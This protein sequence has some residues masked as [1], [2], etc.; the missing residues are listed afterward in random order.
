M[1]N[2]TTLFPLV[3]NQGEQMG[4]GLEA[5]RRTRCWLS[6][7]W[8]EN[9]AEDNEAKQGWKR[10]TGGLKWVDLE[11]NNIGKRTWEKCKKYWKGEWVHLTS[12][13][14]PSSPPFLH[15]FILWDC[16]KSGISPQATACI[17]TLSCRLSG[18][19]S[20][21]LILGFAPI[22]L[23]HTWIVILKSSD[24]PLNN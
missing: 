17:W 6:K 18:T 23:A 16:I 8:A 20:P 9:K 5:G 10:K 14:C 7:E 3:S 1:H 21:H 4:T 13:L 11:G 12:P 2:C 24:L 19:H 15:V 22:P